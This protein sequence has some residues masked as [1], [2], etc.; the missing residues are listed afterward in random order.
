[1]PLFVGGQQSGAAVMEA[2]VA[3]NPP[4]PGRRAGSDPTV[5]NLAYRETIR[6][7]DVAGRERGV[8]AAGIL[9]IDLTETGIRTYVKGLFRRGRT[10]DEFIVPHVEDMQLTSY[11]DW[12]HLLAK[13]PH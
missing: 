5:L 12:L 13:L 10:H 3:V 2:T 8:W 7:P 9:R 11:I 6:L 4:A 1:M